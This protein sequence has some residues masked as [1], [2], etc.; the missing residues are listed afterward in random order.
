MAFNKRRCSD[1]PTPV[2]WR[3]EEEVKEKDRWTFSLVFLTFLNWFLS[4]CLFGYGSTLVK[5]VNV[6][7]KAF[8]LL[9]LPCLFLIFLKKRREWHLPPKRHVFFFFFFPR[10]DARA[11]NINPWLPLKHLLRLTD[12]ST[13]GLFMAWNESQ[14]L[15]KMSPWAGCLSV[16]NWP[17][18]LGSTWAERMSNFVFYSIIQHLV[19]DHAPPHPKE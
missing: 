16:Q 2:R 4:L 6:F 10:Q 5:R 9:N 12:F 19:G 14:V 8:P 3:G 18:V 17:M 13:F 15:I 7:F 1:G 11:D